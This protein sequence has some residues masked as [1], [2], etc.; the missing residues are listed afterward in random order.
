MKL[1]YFEEEPCLEHDHIL[2]I[3]QDDFDKLLK[4]NSSQVKQYLYTVVLPQIKLPEYQKILETWLKD[5][6]INW[7]L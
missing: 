7:K 4:M 3:N 2:P 6:K 5:E 1:T